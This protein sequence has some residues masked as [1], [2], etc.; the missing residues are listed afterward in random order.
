MDTEITPTPDSIRN[1]PENDPLTSNEFFD[2]WSKFL[3]PET[4]I[5]PD[6][7]DRATVFQEWWK[8][9]GAA[10]DEER[11]ITAQIA[12]FAREQIRKKIDPNQTLAILTSVSEEP[13]ARNNSHLKL[14]ASLLE[15]L[16]T[17]GQLTIDQIYGN[18]HPAYR[19][20]YS[21]LMN[22]RSS[23]IFSSPTTPQ[24]KGIPIP[25]REAFRLSA[26][27]PVTGKPKETK[28]LA[29]EWAKVHSQRGIEGT[30]KLQ[31]IVKN[32]SVSK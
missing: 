25:V 22:H 30:Q 9:H 28:S 31:Q 17:P 4:N 7:E 11:D 8:K 15:S 32:G 10:D 18:L 14:A 21:Q 26:W 24:L 23:G 29:V 12:D 27:D 20:P 6:A 1:R 16:M 2:L 3:N 5:H 19:G 13:F